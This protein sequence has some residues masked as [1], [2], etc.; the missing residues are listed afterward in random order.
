MLSHFSHVW[1]FVI[2]WTVACQAPLSLGFSRQEHWVFMPSSSRFTQGSSSLDISCFGKQEYSIKLFWDYWE[3]EWLCFL[4]FFPCDSHQLRFLFVHLFV[5]T[6]TKCSIH[7]LI[8]I[9]VRFSDQ[10]DHQW[11]LFSIPNF[12][13]YHWNKT[14]DQHFSKDFRKMV[15]TNSIMLYKHQLKTEYKPH[16]TFYWP[17]VS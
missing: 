5:F 7:V 11:T 12:S 16:T 9:V 8:L 13:K 1:L 6:S 17:F 2:L 14:M 10:V 3:W 4:T 15:K